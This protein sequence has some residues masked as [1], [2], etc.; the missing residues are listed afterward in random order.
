MSDGNV[1][2]PQQTDE[3]V[4]HRSRR[5]VVAIVVAI[6]VSVIVLVILV[7][8]AFTSST[9]YCGS[10]HSM[11]Q[12]FRT[13]KRGAHSSVPCSKCHVPPGTLAAFK[14]RSKETRNIWLSYLNMKPSKD[15]QSPP[16]TENCVS[17]HPLKG[18]MGIP[19]K[20]RMPHAKHINQ[21]NLECVDCHDH[22]AHAA[23]GQSSSVSMA[24]CTMCHE[25]TND[26]AQCDFCHY[27]P[28]EG[29][30]SHPTDFLDEHGKLALA[31]EQDCIRCH[32]NKAQFCD[33]CHARPTPGHYS[34]NWPYA[35]GLEA[36]KDRARC[37]GCHSEKQLCN[38][39]HTVDHPADWA[40]SHAPVAAKGDRSC[41]VCHPRQMC[42]DCHAAKGVT[43]TP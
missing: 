1:E 2:A 23:P 20:L 30:K 7:P 37:L 43:T 35:H 3:E 16:A 34:G 38:Q 39:C 27:T 42:I 14:W 25:Q 6:V 15:S 41:L 17:C 19:A 31:N 12:A 11:E 4:R 8:V 13:W 40:T 36:K 29:G 21:N 32:H 10:C 28:P 26:P 33:R 24:P 5:F 9:S 18:L 22:T